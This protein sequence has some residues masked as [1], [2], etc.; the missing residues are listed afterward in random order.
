MTVASAPGRVFTAPMGRD[1]VSADAVI[2]RGAEQEVLRSSLAAAREGVGGVVLLSGPAGIGKTRLAELLAEDAE[3]TGIPVRWGRCAHDEGA[4]PLW[5]WRRALGPLVAADPALAEAL[6]AV[7]DQPTR[8]EDAAAAR[9]LLQGA[10]V[11][12]LAAAAEPGGLVL[13]LED[14]QWADVAS[15]DLLAH[16]AADVRR[17]RLLVVATHREPPGGRLGRVLPELVA[18]SGVRPLPLGPLPVGGVAA[19]LSAVAGAAVAPAA[20]S[21]VAQRS[22]GNPLYV[23]ALVRVLG[24]DLLRSDPDL[25]GVERLLAASP[26]LR[27]LAAAGTAELGDAAHRLVDV[28]SVLGEEVDP[29][30]L[31]EVTGVPVAEVAVRLDE[32]EAAGVL[33]P[34][35]DLPGR[36]RFAHA[37]VRDGVRA[38]LAD[39]ARRHWHR[40]AATVLELRAGASAARAGEIASHWLRAAT[41]AEPL[42]RGVHWARLAADQVAGLD[43]EE[44]VRLLAA[45]TAVAGPAELDD[46][47][48]A[49]LLLE[50]ATAEYRAGRVAESLDHSTAAS[51]AAVRAG[52]VEVQ[53]RA[54]LV[55]QGIGDPGAAGRLVGLCDRAL[56]A[57]AGALPPALHARL[58]AQRSQAD[59]DPGRSLPAR[60]GAEAALVEAES[61]GDVEALL[62]A[63][64]ASVQSLDALAPPEL[65][66]ALASR[67]L[68]LL[69]PAGAHLSRL[70]PHLWALDAEVVRG[71]AAGL[72]EAYRRLEVL[73]HESRL[74][75]VRWHLLRARAARAALRGRFAEARE[76]NEE[77]AGVGA[78]LQEPS[79]VGMSHAFRYCLARLTG[80]R[81]DLGEDWVARA[82]DA[83]DI[84]IIAASRASALLLLGHAEEARTDYRSVL[85]QLPRLP[86]DGRW[87]ATLYALVDAAVDLRDPVGAAALLEQ[88]L[89]AAP[90][91]GGPGSGNMWAP[92]SGWR[93]V[94]RLAAVCGR[95]DDAVAALERALE[96]DVAFLARADAV[97]VRLELAQVL[98]AGG[99]APADRDRAVSLAEQ[100]AREARG[101]GMPG[102]LSAAD[103]LLRRCA[104]A[105]AQ[106]DPL[107][108]RERE[109]A[110]LVAQALSN[111][112]VAERLVLSERTVETHVRSIL[113]KLGLRRRTDVVRR[114]TTGD[115]APV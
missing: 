42:R 87:H 14:L 10:A 47:A 52:S 48:Q 99:S 32:A 86:R 69:P 38:Q 56:G 82:A 67:A 43:P 15:L 70:W 17:T 16:L 1:R 28:A 57:P 81:A 61:S 105:R 9:F 5:P 11:D 88:L 111:R 31:S 113:A 104:T 94:G 97:H 112:E 19:Y 84:P 80:D 115:S 72:D 50:L 40:R 108:P 59:C 7:Q 77:A 106:A 20:V 89:P 103:A 18:L 44:A 27:S 95:R 4:P 8:A 53:A 64:H 49:E 36:L 90:Y 2:G 12:A 45:A 107:T 78:R 39:A 33:T 98:V 58:L 68:E 24:N 96:T 25:E 66:S 41:T 74:P 21:L 73:S 114:W 35:V 55:V 60:S 51:D 23:R 65:R 13:V 63:V 29:A 3:L 100:A 22:G 37:L 46:L 93:Q 109:V 34:V 62:A 76:A 75:L 83:P 101:L 91:C 30:L 85:A 79:A 92:G 110:E 102:P 54:A 71:N 6:A 26:E